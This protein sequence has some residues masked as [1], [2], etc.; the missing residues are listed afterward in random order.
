MSRDGDWQPIVTMEMFAR[1]QR[2]L[3]GKAVETTTPTPRADDRF[4]LRQFVR[5][6]LCDKPLTGSVS[7]GHG[8]AY[9]YYHCMKRDHVR[10]R[11]EK[12]E[13]EWVAMLERMQPKTGM[14]NAV[15]TVL[16]KAWE[17]M[18]TSSE[19]A[20]AV[21]AIKTHLAELERQ[22]AN[23]L[24]TMQLGN[25]DGDDFAVPYRKVKDDIQAAQEQLALAM[26]ADVDVDTAIDF[27]QHVYW[28]LHFSWQTKDLAAKQAIQKAVSPSGLKIPSSDGFGTCIK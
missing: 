11:A 2:V 3:D 13:A 14:E 15:L 25:L 4:P 9:A 24:H 17:A 10:V 6:A 18:N 28:N 23:L 12:L 22:K 8:G 19:T 5:C 1:T 21:E 16:R 20:A 26:A 7:T 27:M